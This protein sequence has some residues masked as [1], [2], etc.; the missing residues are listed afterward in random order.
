MTTTSRRPTPAK[1][2][3]YA[4]VKEHILEGFWP[5]GEML[6]EGEVAAQL[7]V[8]RTPV[9]EAFLLLEA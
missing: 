7:G 6:S 9:R 5:G 3:A 4:H 1:D 8:S 2:R